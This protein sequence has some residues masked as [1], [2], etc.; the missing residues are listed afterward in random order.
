MA[1]RVSEVMPA[2]CPVEHEPVAVE[3]GALHVYNQLLDEL[4]HPR[5]HT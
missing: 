5:V 1:S 4:I 3:N 2:E